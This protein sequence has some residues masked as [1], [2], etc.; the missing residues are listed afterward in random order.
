MVDFLSIVLL[1]AAGAAFILT[2][3]EKWGWREWLMV[4]AP[5]E[6]LYRLFLC[7]FCC[8]WWVLVLLTLCVVIIVRDAA[9][10]AVPVFATPIALRLW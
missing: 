7:K 1:M 6:F 10:L 2:L 8:T 3:A 9:L 4:H 5:N